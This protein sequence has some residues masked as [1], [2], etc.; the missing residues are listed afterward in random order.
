[1]IFGRGGGGGVDQPRDQ[2]GRISCR[3]ASSRCRAARSA[4]GA[5]T[6]DLDQPLERQRGAFALNG[7]VRG[8]RQLPRRR[9]ACERY[10]INPTLTIA[11]SDADADHARLRALARRR[12][13]PIAA[14]RRTRAAR[15]TSPIDDL[16][17]QSATTATCRRSVNLGSA[18]IEHRAGALDDP[19]PHALRRLRPLLP[20]LRARRGDRRPDAGRADRLQQRHRSGRTCSTRPTSTYTGVDR[21]RSAT[22]CSPAPRSAAS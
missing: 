18:T 12:A 7:D 8:L 9:R 15:P 3:C 19:Q 4:T 5:S 20:E 22:R 2:G 13:S 21:A 1:M 14:S 6:A 17:R 11:P 10:G 16:L